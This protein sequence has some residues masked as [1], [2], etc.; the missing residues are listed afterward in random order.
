MTDPQVRPGVDAS[1]PAAAGEPSASPTLRRAPAVLVALGILLV[2]ATARAFPVLAGGGLFGLGN[3]DDGVHYAAAVAFTSGEL[4]YRDFL[5]LHPP[6]IVLLLTPAALLG[7]V[8]GDPTG[9]AVARVGWWVLGGVNAVLVARIV[10][11]FG[12]AAA[13]VGGLGYALFFPAVY[14]EHTALL[15]PPATT[16]LLVSLLLVRATEPGARLSGRRV[17]L[18]G[19][20]LGFAVTLKIWGVVPVLVVV[21]WL[22]GGRRFRTAAAYLAGAVGICLVVYLPF[23]L[24]APSQMWRLVVTDQVGRRPLDVAFVKR[25]TDLSGMSLWAPAS[26]GLTPLIVAALVVGVVC[27]LVAVLLRRSRLLGLLTV[28]LVGM[29]LLTPSWFVHYS[30]LTAAPVVLVTATATGALLAVLRRAT[31]RTWVGGV[32]VAVGLVGLLGYAHQFLDLRL[33]RAFPGPALARALVGVPGCIA[34]DDPST[35]IQTDLLRRNIARGC[36]IE[37][38]LGGV[39]YDLEHPDSVQVSRARNPNWQ[40]YCL[41]YYRASDAVISVRFRSGFGYSRS[42][43]QVYESWPELARVDRYV[44]RIPQPA[45]P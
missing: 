3:Y 27:T 45:T 35:L 28:A 32:L 42:T 14:S 25:L 43:G 12:R 21:G 38:D 9:M 5:L 41:D 16:C 15:E 44:V 33:I 26:G 6:G 31:G 4:P 18:A 36:R 11:P 24:S 2:A 34:T 22:L 19:A 30:G 39:N 40:Q 29:L 8:L 17:L 20:V 13:L 7:A 1:D 23:F 10:L 37:I